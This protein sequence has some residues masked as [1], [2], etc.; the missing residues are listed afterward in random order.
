MKAETEQRYY[1]KLW[2]IIR[3]KTNDFTFYRLDPRGKAEL[4]TALLAKHVME[5]YP[6]SVRHAL[7]ATIYQLPNT[8]LSATLSRLL[9]NASR[10]GFSLALKEPDGRRMILVNAGTEADRNTKRT[11]SFTAPSWDDAGELRKTIAFRII[12]ND[13]AFVLQRNLRLKSNTS[14]AAV[15]SSA[16]RNTATP[17]GSFE[18]HFKSLMREQGTSASP[19]ATAR[20]LFST[21]S[22]SQKRRLNLSLNAMGI[23]SNNDMERLLHKWTAEALK[24]LPA[25]AVTKARAREPEYGR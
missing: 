3:G 11:L 2:N 18:K 24:R 10:K 6:A 20:Y 4:D 25:Q 15:L 13:I 21:M 5:R 19:L 22:Y 8:P 12:Q 16:S 17:R 1:A 14:M 7:P 9:M 23:T